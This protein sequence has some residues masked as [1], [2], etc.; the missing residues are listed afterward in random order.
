HL[1]WK[2]HRDLLR[3]RRQHEVDNMSRLV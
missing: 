1:G 2:G 3:K